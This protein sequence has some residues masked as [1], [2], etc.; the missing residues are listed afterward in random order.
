MFLLPRME[1]VEDI[2]SGCGV[3][4][5]QDSTWLGSGNLTPVIDVFESYDPD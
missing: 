4:Q 3:I 2:S 1:R 5:K